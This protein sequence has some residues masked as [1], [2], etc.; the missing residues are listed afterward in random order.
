MAIISGYIDWSTGEKNARFTFRVNNKA[1]ALA[2]IKRL[3]DK[4]S[5]VR[6]AW[7]FD[8]KRMISPIK[9]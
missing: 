5:S 3:K 4:G 6:A 7:Y 2:C 8:R 1:D 9:I